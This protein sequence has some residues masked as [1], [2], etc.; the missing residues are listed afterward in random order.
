MEHT[1]IDGVT[2]GTVAFF[3]QNRE[4]LVGIGRDL[5]VPAFFKLMPRMS[6]YYAMKNEFQAITGDGSNV[7]ISTSL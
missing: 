1:V 5:G 6:H 4:W 3:E 2:D 7:Q